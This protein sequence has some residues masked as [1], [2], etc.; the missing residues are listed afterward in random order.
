MFERIGHGISDA[1]AGKRAQPDAWLKGCGALDEL[2]GADLA[3]T[4]LGVAARGHGLVLKAS[5]F[6][7]R[8]LPAMSAEM[9]ASGKPYK[10][11]KPPA[12]EGIDPEHWAVAIARAAEHHPPVRRQGIPALEA[13]G[14]PVTSANSP[15]DRD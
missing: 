1:I 11:P 10:L 14:I 12:P 13:L 6:P 3:I 5:E 4:S 7:Q 9:R 2:V 8:P 15:V